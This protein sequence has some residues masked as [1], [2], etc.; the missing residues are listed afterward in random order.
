VESRRNRSAR[1]KSAK[2]GEM[3][4][5]TDVSNQDQAQRAAIF[6]GGDSDEKKVVKVVK[7]GYRWEE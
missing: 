4:R 3:E 7:R 1:G 2:G 5:A 6:E